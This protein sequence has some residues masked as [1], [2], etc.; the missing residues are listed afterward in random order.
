M[1]IVTSETEKILNSRVHANVTGDDGIQP[2]KLHSHRADVSLENKQN[3]D[4]LEGKLMSYTANDDGDSFHLQ[5]LDAHCQA[6]KIL[7]IKI[8][9]QVIISFYLF[10]FNLF[11]IKNQK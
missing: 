9:A 11:I 10:Y 6:P 2:T 5:Q 4:A 7:E 8:G 1:G 3:L